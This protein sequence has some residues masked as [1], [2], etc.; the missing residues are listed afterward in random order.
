MQGVVVTGEH[1]NER[2]RPVSGLLKIHEPEHVA[3]PFGASLG[4]LCGEAHLRCH[5][6]SRARHRHGHHAIQSATAWTHIGVCK[7]ASRH[8]NRRRRPH[9][10]EVETRGHGSNSYARE[11]VSQSSV[12]GCST[13]QVST[14]DLLRECGLFPHSCLWQ[15]RGD[16]TEGLVVRKAA[17]TAL[18]IAIVRPSV[19]FALHEI[20]PG[21]STPTVMHWAKLHRLARYMLQYPEKRWDDEYQRTLEMLEVLTDTDCAADTE[22]LESVSCTIERLGGAKQW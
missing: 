17:G 9:I 2:Q 22:T 11:D 18:H 14:T 21:M 5:D 3:A 13:R 6:R 19:Q 4:N 8:Q 15:D 7:V 16:P 20:M 1:E 10:R 12:P